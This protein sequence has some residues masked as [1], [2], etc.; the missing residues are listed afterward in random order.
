MISLVGVSRFR[1][2]RELDTMTAYRQIVPDYA[3]FVF[4]MTPMDDEKV[5]DR[6]RIAASI[7]SFFKQREME[8]FWPSMEHFP[9]EILINSLAMICPF[10]PAEKQALLEA[11][12]LLERAQLLTAL[13][14]MTNAAHGGPTG[15]MQ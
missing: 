10:P 12:S 5:V 2:A 11:P 9:A 4:D 13:I 14:E 6:K 3:P 7:K 15:A 8:N 1:I